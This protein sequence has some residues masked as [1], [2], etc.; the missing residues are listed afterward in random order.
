MSGFSE[1]DKAFEIRT[2]FEVD[3][4]YLQALDSLRDELIGQGIDID[5]GDGR[6]IFIRAVRKLNER[7]M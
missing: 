1:E 5:S 6:K 4:I 2:S 7:F 3:R